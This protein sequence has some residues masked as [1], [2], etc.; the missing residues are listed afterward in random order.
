M[1]TASHSILHGGNV[2]LINERA[3][4][5]VRSRGA[6]AAG[7]CNKAPVPANFRNE[8]PRPGDECENFLGSSGAYFRLLTFLRHILRL[9]RSSVHLC[10]RANRAREIFP[11]DRIAPQI[12]S[13]PAEPADEFCFIHCARGDFVVLRES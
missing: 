2:C 9:L 10:A 11:R 3:G 8:Q 13:S 12:I 1:S 4:E 6:T 7:L 5:R